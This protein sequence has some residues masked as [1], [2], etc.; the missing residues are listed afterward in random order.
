VAPHAAA[1]YRDYVPA[2]TKV[3]VARDSCVVS[4]PASRVAGPRPRPCMAMVPGALPCGVVPLPLPS[5]GH[6]A[7]IVRASGTHTHTCTAHILATFSTFELKRVTPHVTHDRSS[8]SSWWRLWSCLTR[9][10]VTPWRVG[11]GCCASRP[12]HPGRGAVK[13]GGDRISSALK[14][15][16]GSGIG[17]VS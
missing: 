15:G 3:L 14:T 9:V 17:S 8:W 11:V 2:S 10:T 1:H 12:P 13:T 7:R 5:P 16:S 4:S 6:R